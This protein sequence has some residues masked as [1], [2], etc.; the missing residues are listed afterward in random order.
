MPEPQSPTPNQLPHN[1]HHDVLIVIP[2]MGDPE[3]LTPCVRR[4]LQHTDGR[5]VTL[6]IVINGFD[7]DMGQDTNETI[8]Q[9]AR[10]AGV[11]IG[12]WIAPGPLGFGK[13]VNE[14]LRMAVE[15]GAGLPPAVVIL[16]DDARPTAGWLDGMLRALDPESIGLSGEAPDMQGARPAHPYDPAIY[17][18]IGMVGPVSNLVA[19]SQLVQLPNGANPDAFAAKLRRDHSGQVVA[20]SF[21]SGFCLCL[22]R[23]ALEEVLLPREEGKL[24]TR[25]FDDETFP[26]GGFEDNDL[27]VRL[28][29]L[30]WRRVVALDSYVHHLGHQTLDRHF[31]GQKRG[32][33]NRLAYYQKW[34]GHPYMLGHGATANL[35]IHGVRAPSPVPSPTLIALYRVKLETGNDLLMLRDSIQRLVATGPDGRPV[36][37]G[38]ALLFTADP[39]APGRPWARAQDW[40]LAVNAMTQADKAMVASV[41][42]SGGEVHTQNAL[43]RWVKSLAGRDLPVSVDIYA[44]GD[45]RDERNHAIAL[46][47]AMGAN[48]LLS[49]DHDEI[50]E[51][52]VTR[53]EIERLMRHPDP[54]VSHWD[55]GWVNHWDNVRLVR[56]DAPWGDGGSYRS[57][58]RGFRLWRASPNPQRPNR[59]HAGNDLGLHCGNC[60]D[61]DL[62]AKRVSGLR[63]RHLGYVRGAD[64]VR[65]HARYM[66]IDPNPNPSLTG[67]GYGHLIHE[68]GMRISPYVPVDGIGLSMLVHA[69]EDPENVARHLDVMHGVV[70]RVVLVWTSDEAP[71]ADLIAY[72]R[73]FGAEIVHHALNDDFAAARN[74]GLDAL[75]ATP[76]GRAGL[77]WAL[78]LDPDE[79]LQDAFSDPVALRRMAECSD[80]HGWMFRFANLRP[81]G[82]GEDATMSE[83]VRMIRLIPQIRYAGRVHEGF[84]RAFQKLSESGEA[85]TL[86]PAPFIVINPGLA[87]DDDAM[88]AKL[89]FYQK[90]TLMELR[91]DP[92]NATAWVS[93]GMQLVND[94]DQEGA[95]ECFKRSIAADDRGFLAWRELA[96][97]YMRA[98]A[99]MMA[100]A[101][102]RTGMGHPWRPIADAQV[103]WLRNNVPPQPLIG[104]ARRGEKAPPLEI[105][106]G[107]GEHQTVVNLEGVVFGANKQDRTWNGGYEPEDGPADPE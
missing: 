89:R 46:A 4:V 31:P 95:L 64:R 71:S 107:P 22:R 47:E 98:G 24:P 102:E 94:G 34:A 105:P 59:I 101:R 104:A 91:E 61:A 1:D 2:T 40:D 30:G 68:E 96:L 82:S 7:R 76:K 84:D 66:Q 14:G 73:L 19:G 86:R 25:L 54:L 11:Q 16:N 23:E 45:E 37:D 69:G 50:L 43:V 15:G 93:L 41:A 87:G 85:I 58:M 74:A 38:V 28:E 49:V 3:V 60:P 83:C 36:V 106:P 55:F 5:R 13:A 8:H 103:E 32:M 63:F 20:A 90:L 52:R 75:A 12:T 42:N 44:S 18:P 81:R 9:M 88:E 65:K 48:W 33:A 100:E 56:Q 92:N 21:L 39:V 57:G 26:I 6:A 27:C 77:G 72:A 17:G 80:A 97:W 35:L 62:P 79:V 10:R 67:G 51:D 78:A 99:E 53:T 29:I 70:D